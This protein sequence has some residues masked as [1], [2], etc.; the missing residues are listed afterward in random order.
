M[1]R[2]RRKVSQRRDAMFNAKV[3]HGSLG[4]GKYMAQATGDIPVPT[5]PPCPAPNRTM[6]T[7]PAPQSTTPGATLCTQSTI[8]QTSHMTTQQT[9]GT[10]QT[11]P[12]G[13][14]ASAWTVTSATDTAPTASGGTDAAQTTTTSTAIEAS[15]ST[16]ARTQ[17][18]PPTLSSTKT[19]AGD[20]EVATMT[21]S[22]P[23]KRALSGGTTP[24]A[25][26][27]STASSGGAYA[28]SSAS[29]QTTLSETPSTQTSSN[30]PDCIPAQQAKGLF[31]S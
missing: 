2:V 5:P 9:Q 25:A 10:D 17:T 24:S 6:F 4:L 29:Q 27:K 18:A 1:A 14:S 21:S 20:G 15:P 8:S 19:A 26:S 31:Y 11:A 23:S 22:A 7:T 30:L 13:G 3:L 12:P 16:N 28:S